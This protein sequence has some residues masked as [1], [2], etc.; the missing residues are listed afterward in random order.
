MLIEFIPEQLYHYSL[1]IIL[2]SLFHSLHLF[3]SGG[4]KSPSSSISN[5]INLET[6]VI[7]Q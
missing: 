5:T 1:L 6:P 4:S 7:L 3:I 2:H